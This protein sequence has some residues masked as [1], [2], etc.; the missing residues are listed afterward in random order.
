MGGF[1]NSSFDFMSII[2]LR[3][4]RGEVA[5]RPNAPARLPRCLM[6]PPIANANASLDEPRVARFDVLQGEEDP[7]RFLHHICAA[8]V[9]TSA[10]GIQDQ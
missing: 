8:T 10:G 5:R 1:S 2:L 4:L 6:L 7:T 3:Y 9:V